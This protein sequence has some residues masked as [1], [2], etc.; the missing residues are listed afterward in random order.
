MGEKE[1]EAELQKLRRNNAAELL[2]RLPAGLLSNSLGDGQ[3]NSNTSRRSMLLLLLLCYCTLMVLYVMPQIDKA[4]DKLFDLLENPF[5][6]KSFV[7][8]LID[9]LFI[10]IFPE[11]RPFLSGMDTLRKD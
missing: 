1:E 5:L 10:E 6:L 8:I 4:V 7:F 2:S 3:V 9:M 11:L